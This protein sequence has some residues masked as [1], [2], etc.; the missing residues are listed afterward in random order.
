M[1]NQI[2]QAKLG[3][4]LFKLGLAA[5][6]GV[7]I[8]VYGVVVGDL[9]FAGLGGMLL[10]AMTLLAV[11]LMDIPLKY[12]YV[13]VGV[14]VVGMVPAVVMNQVNAPPPPRDT[15][16]VQAEYDEKIREAEA[17][18]TATDPAVRLSSVRRLVGIRPMPRDA[19]EK[20]APLVSD[21]DPAVRLAAI[22]ALRP[23][24]SSHSG[25]VPATRDVA[26]ALA[27][28]VVDDDPALATAALSTLT[29]MGDA[30]TPAAPTLRR[31]LPT[32]PALGRIDAAR[33]LLEID[34]GHAEDVVTVVGPLTSDSDEKTA[35]AAIRLVRT[36]GPAAKSAGPRL[37]TTIRGTSNIE[38]MLEASETL[39]SVDRKR[40][41]EAVPALL[42]LIKEIDKQTSGRLKKPVAYYQAGADGRVPADG[43]PSPAMS[44][45]AGRPVE[46]LSP[47]RNRA[48]KL[49]VLI[50]LPAA[51][52]VSPTSPQGG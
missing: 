13:A 36:A 42:G 30:A 9:Y 43:E 4:K 35:L 6:F 19:F 15:A 34:P 26:R 25:D 29:A 41:G 11:V 31:A 38:V 23:L 10:V 39:Q 14:A 37:V 52:K 48:M 40:A 32:M 33:L 22:D 50:D 44:R 2:R 7:G 8:W 17:G 5:L 20:I 45:L 3:Y 47:V 27:D 46:P 18:L 24:A 1:K 28:A 12:L 51:R 49:L 16:T 21:P